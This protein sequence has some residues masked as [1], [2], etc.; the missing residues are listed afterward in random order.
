MFQHRLCVGLLLGSVLLSAATAVR[1]DD[2][3]AAEKFSIVFSQWKALDKQIDDVVAEFPKANEE[4]Q[5]ELREQY[6]KLTAQAKTLAQQLQSAAILA[7]KELPNT[8]KDVTKILLAL[9]HVSVLRDDYRTAGEITSLLHIDRNSL[10]QSIR[11]LPR[12]R[13]FKRGMGG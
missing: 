6:A 13:I 7:Y 10:A 4:R 3:P 9:A 12:T 11:V 5:K 8:N 1:A 2:K